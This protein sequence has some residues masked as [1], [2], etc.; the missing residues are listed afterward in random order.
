MLRRGAGS[1][2]VVQDV[3]GSAAH[4][5]VAQLEQR[6]GYPSTSPI[7]ILRCKA[8]DQDLDLTESLGRS[9]LRCLLRFLGR[10]ASDAGRIRNGAGHARRVIDHVYSAALSP[11]IRDLA[12]KRCEHLLVFL[13]WF[14]RADFKSARHL[15]AKDIR[16]R[17]V[18]E[19]ETNEIISPG[20][21]APLN[22]RRFAD[23]DPHRRPLVQRSGRLRRIPPRIADPTPCCARG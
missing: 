5:R 9:E 4:Y 3:R 21:R 7:P 19:R 6:T 17:R 23:R 16:Q 18:C 13:Y 15:I 22:R 8:D 2:R 11:Q 14:K 20:R 12:N 1:F 10:S